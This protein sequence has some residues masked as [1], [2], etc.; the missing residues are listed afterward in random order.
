MLNSSLCTQA[1]L[2]SDA[3]RGWAIQIKENPD[4]LHRK[5]WEWCYICQ[6]L[7]EHDML[8]PG[9][10]GLGF[11]VGQEPL[12]AFFA[13]R[14]CEIVATDLDPTQAEQSGAWVSTNQHAA[15]LD[16]LNKRGL[17]DPESFRR[18]VSFQFADMNHIPPNLRGFDFVWS[19]C[20]FEH[21]GNI[22]LGKRFLVN[23]MAC[24]KLGGI[25]IH[26]TEYNV[27]SNEDT[28][29]S[30]GFVIFRRRDIE[31]MVRDLKQRGCWVAP[32]DFSLGD[33]P[34]DQIVEKEPYQHQ[35]HLKLELGGYVATSIGLIIQKSSQVNLATRLGHWLRREGA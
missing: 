5:L 2:S 20:S 19:S 30:G 31:D 28:V 23:M 35:V 18:L 15:S 29:T 27:Q 6:A 1:Q 17:C 10:R 9:R 12:P 4:H 3:F 7:H 8:R 21:L 13:S 26:T 22:E 16:P 24:L 14:G 34:A 11:A 25:A 32:L 33:G